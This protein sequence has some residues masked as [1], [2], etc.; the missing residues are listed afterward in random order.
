[1]QSTA[2][3]GEDQA[4]LTT[5]DNPGGSAWWWSSGDILRACD[6][7][8]DGLRAVARI[9]YDGVVQGSVQDLYSDGDCTDDSG[10]NLPEGKVLYIQACLKDG[11]NGAL[12]F[13]S[14]WQKGVA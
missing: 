6:I 2:W 12:Q 10:I 14:S 8:S 3:A 4:A 9:K 13:C 7:Q 1:M 5:D 11:A